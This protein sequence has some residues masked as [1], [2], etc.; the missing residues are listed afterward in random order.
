MNQRRHQTGSFSGLDPGHPG[1]I[2]GA[3][4]SGKMPDFRRRKRGQHARAIG[5][6]LEGAQ[7]RIAHDG[8]VAVR[9]AGFGQLAQR[10]LL[11]APGRS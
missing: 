2:Q 6:G 3:G 5:P 11:S 10:H 8:Q 7:R 1:R 4:L 9:A